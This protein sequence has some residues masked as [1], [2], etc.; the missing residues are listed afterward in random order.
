M[1]VETPARVS[2]VHTRDASLDAA[3]RHSVYAIDTQVG[4]LHVSLQRG[5]PQLARW[6]ADA[7]VRGGALLS[8]CNPGAQPLTDADNRARGAR[9]QQWL[10]EQDHR[11]VPAEGGAADRSWVEPSVFVLGLDAAEAEDCAR[12]FGQLAWLQVD[13]GGAATLR[14]VTPAGGRDAVEQG[15]NPAPCTYS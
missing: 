9:L 7:G 1:G 11:W 10:R 3:F 12:C 5:S 15:D 14:Y 8:A 4:R 13:A 6:L 2:G